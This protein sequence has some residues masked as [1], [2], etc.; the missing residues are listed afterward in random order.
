[1]AGA[2]YGRTL[3]INGD[4]NHGFGLLVWANPWAADWSAPTMAEVPID[5]TPSAFIV[6]SEVADAMHRGELS[7]RID[8]VQRPQIMVHEIVKAKGIDM[9]ACEGSH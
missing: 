2:A 8:P 5:Q 1:M 7:C 3:R 4:A 6:I 9:S